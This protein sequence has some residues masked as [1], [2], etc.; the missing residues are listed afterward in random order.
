MNQDSNLLRFKIHSQIIQICS[1][2]FGKSDMT[3]RASVKVTCIVE[4]KVS[5]HWTELEIFQK[6]FISSINID[7]AITLLLLLMDTSA[8]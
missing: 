2:P 7:H 4:V 1:V 5:C 3:F 6:L 8:I